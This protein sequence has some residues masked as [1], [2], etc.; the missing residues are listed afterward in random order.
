VDAVAAADRGVSQRV[1][2]V[3]ECFA[4]ADGSHDDCVVAAFDEL[5]ALR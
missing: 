2:A 1:R 3:K 5:T 4:D